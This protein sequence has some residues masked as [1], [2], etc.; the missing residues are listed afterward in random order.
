VGD[1]DEIAVAMTNGIILI[2]FHA[3]GEPHSD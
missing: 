3:D 2:S 1:R